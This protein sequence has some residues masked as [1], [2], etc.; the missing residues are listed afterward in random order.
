MFTNI[1]N[2]E[3]NLV[4]GIWVPLTDDTKMSVLLANSTL[5]DFSYS[6]IF[7]LDF[8]KKTCMIYGTVQKGTSRNLTDQQC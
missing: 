7:L 4:I 2:S 3:Y 5:F 8:L 6:D 1:L